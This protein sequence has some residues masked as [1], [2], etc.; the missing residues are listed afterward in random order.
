MEDEHAQE[1][2]DAEQHS[3]EM[4]AGQ[5]EQAHCSSE[6]ENAGGDGEPAA[7][8]IPGR[9]GEGEDAEVLQGKAGEGEG[10]ENAGAGERAGH[11]FRASGSWGL[12]RMIRERIGG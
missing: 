1:Q 5:E 12:G 7:D 3:R 6:H 2:R 4:G 10:E 9:A 8:G 11:R